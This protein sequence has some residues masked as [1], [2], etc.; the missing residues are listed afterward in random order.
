MPTL[1]APRLIPPDTVPVLRWGIVGTGIAGALLNTLH[2]HT[3]H[4]AIAVA[5]RD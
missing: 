3:A 4:G 1:P 5:A 2:R